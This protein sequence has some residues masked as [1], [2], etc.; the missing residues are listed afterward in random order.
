MKPYFSYLTPLLLIAWG[1][2]LISLYQGAHLIKAASAGIAS[3]NPMS[4]GP[5]KNVPVPGLSAQEHLVL[6]GG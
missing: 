3:L 5:Q 1:V 6:Y 2:S 4:F